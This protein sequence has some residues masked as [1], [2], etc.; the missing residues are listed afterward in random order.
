MTDKT[1]KKHLYV[2]GIYYC[3]CKTLIIWY[4]DTKK[5]PEMDYFPEIIEC[6]NCKSSITPKEKLRI[7][8][9]RDLVNEFLRIS[10]SYDFKHFLMIDESHVHFSWSKPEKMN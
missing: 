3:N 5:F 7:D 4:P 2:F 1:K 9:E 8:P 10:S 6:P